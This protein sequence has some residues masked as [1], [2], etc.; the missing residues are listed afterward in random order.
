MKDNGQSI[1]VPGWARAWLAASTAIFVF[2]ICG[3]AMGLVFL[4]IRVNNFPLM[5]IV[6]FLHRWDYILAPGIALI[7]GVLASRWI[8]SK[9]LMKSRRA[10]L[11]T[12]L[13]FTALASLPIEVQTHIRPVMVSPL[14]IAIER[15]YSMETVEA[16]IDRYPRLVN[17]SNREWDHYQPLVNAAYDG[18]TNLVE[19]LIRKGADV[20]LAVQELQGINAESS[21]RLVLR[22]SESHNK[23]PTATR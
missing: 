6:N 21:V 9:F 5:T 13:A 12:S 7:F 3:L 15:R 14:E 20:D 16:I 4:W 10:W 8:E 17:G 1:T 22:C 2:R 18:R 11:L 23:T 19:L